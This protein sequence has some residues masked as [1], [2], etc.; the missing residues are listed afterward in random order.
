MDWL[1]DLDDD[2]RARVHATPA[3]SWLEPM[4]AR[5][6]D[7]R[8]DDSEWVFERKLDGIRYLAFIAGGEARLLTRN[9]I[10]HRHPA[11]EA[12]LLAQ[13]SRDFVVDGEMVSGN[14]RPGAPRG[15]G[16]DRT[17]YAVFDVL[18]IDGYDV[19]NLPLNSRQQ[20]LSDEFGWVEPLALVEPL[21]ENGIVAYERACREGWEG[22]MAK[23]RDSVYEHKRSKAWLKMKCD[24]SQEFVVAG[25]TEPSGARVGFGAL[26]IGYYDG[27]D[28]VYAGRLG[29]GF[30]TQLLRDLHER[31]LSIE[32]AAPPFTAGTGLPKKGAHWV[33]P[34]I[35]VDAAFME[36]TSEGKLRHP[37]FVRIR[38][39]KAPTD[40]VRET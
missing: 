10:R 3:P 9:R 11:V 17:Q 19:T 1:S 8:F 6:T 25:F 36:W 35:V 22:V 33:R 39:D 21:K 30:N 38:V 28:F 37:R 14:R 4:A 5:L 16:D 7:A 23:R 2:L 15:R 29:T 24:S 32:V 34:E 27:A 18:R 40:V 13:S 12:T 31:L 26:L 20:I